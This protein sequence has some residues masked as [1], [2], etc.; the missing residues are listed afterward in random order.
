[1]IFVVVGSQEPFDRLIKAV[2]LWASENRHKDVFAQIGR[3]DLRPRNID[4]IEF[5][6]PQAF[7]E[8]LKRAQII[9]SHAGMGIIL[10][11][12]CHSKPIIVMPRLFLYHEVRSD[13][14]LA[15]ARSLSRLGYIS[16]AYNG[17]ELIHKLRSIKKIKP[18]H[19]IGPYASMSL[20]DEIKKFIF[21]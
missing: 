18:H 7:E 16:V 6:P 21:I 3:T 5:L 12:L 13:H 2:D 17:V 14:Q 1:M 9:I 15:T 4:W 19:P 11:A 10:N 20:I 8:K